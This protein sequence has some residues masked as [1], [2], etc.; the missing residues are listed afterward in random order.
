MLFS[1]VD[2]AD[3]CTSVL[4]HLSFSLWVVYDCLFFG[5]ASFLCLFV[6]FVRKTKVEHAHKH[7]GAICSALPSSC[8][9]IISRADFEQ[10]PVIVVYPVQLLASGWGAT[11]SQTGLWAAS[12]E[13]ANIDCFSLLCLVC[14]CRRSFWLLLVF[15][16]LFLLSICC[17]LALCG[18]S[19]LFGFSHWCSHRQP[20][21]I[22]TRASR[23]EENRHSISAEM[24]SNWKKGRT[25]MR[26]K[27]SLLFMLSLSYSA[28][29]ASVLCIGEQNTRYFVCFS[30][31]FQSCYPDSSPFSFSSSFLPS[32]FTISNPSK[33]WEQRSRWS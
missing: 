13:L 7:R 5:S 23:K 14:L 2:F 25:D 6:Y 32:C 12:A 24:R 21:R 15:H 29:L 17:F 4:W 11:T 28:L 19:G 20:K 3:S 30:L 27:L 18:S 26:N 33:K 31:S 1:L 9:K 8:L 16:R 22:E 10:M